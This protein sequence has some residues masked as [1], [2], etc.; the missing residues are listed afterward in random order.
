MITEIT[1]MAKIS[2]RANATIKIMVGTNS[3]EGHA[4]WAR[5]RLNLSTLAKNSSSRFLQKFILF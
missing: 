5:N 3:S 2:S 4:F 1:K